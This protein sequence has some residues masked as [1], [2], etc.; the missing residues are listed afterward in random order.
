MRSTKTA[1]GAVHQQQQHAVLFACPV[2]KQRNLLGTWRARSIEVVMEQL[3]D[4]KS[5]EL[6]VYKSVGDSL[7]HQRIQIDSV[8]RKQSL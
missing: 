8:R 4:T 5:Y 3:F 6:L 2:Y 7:A 1:G